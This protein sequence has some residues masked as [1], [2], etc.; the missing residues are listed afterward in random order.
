MFL[1]KKVASLATFGLVSAG[2]AVAGIG[3]LTANAQPGAYEAP[4]TIQ[5]DY[6][7]TLS[8]D[9]LSQPQSASAPASSIAPVNGADE[10]ISTTLPA[11]LAAL[12]AE[13]DE[14]ETFDADQ[15]CLATAIYY[16]A[17]SESLAGQLAVARVIVN[18]AASGRFPRSLCGVVTQAGQFSFVRGGRLPDADKNDAQWRNARAIAQIA[19]DNEW[20]SQ[21]EGALFFHASRVSP[22]WGRQRLTQIDNHIFYR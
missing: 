4:V 12:V 16:E 3:S 7:V 8:D 19:V 6:A 2:F 5:P 9:A 18:R 10:A 20:K 17:R 13:Q 22:G 21:A 11:S 14:G 1:T 15:N